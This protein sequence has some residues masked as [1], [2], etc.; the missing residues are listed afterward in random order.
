MKASFFTHKEMGDGIFRVTAAIGE[1]IYLVVGEDRAAVIDTGMGVGSLRSYIAAL[2]SKPLIVVNTH[3]HPDHAGGNIE[4]EDCRM[5][6]A[7]E[8]WYRKMCSKAYRDHDLQNFPCPALSDY[9]A[10]LAQ[11]GPLPKPLLDGEVLDL[12]GRTLTAIL[13]PG[14][15]PGS[16][17][18]LD[19]QSRSVF[20][21]DSLSAE[22]VWL[23]DEYSESL[24]T[25]FEGLTH[26]EDRAGHFSRCFVGHLPGE[27]SVQTLQ[28]TLACVKRVLLR[29]GVGTPT[30]TFAGEGLLYRYGASAILYNPNQC[31]E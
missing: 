23:Y 26:L 11:S 15:T 31:Y 3:G 14:H 6:P 19:S 5:H 17:C 8:P 12:G 18:L 16:L 30:K 21:G 7:D 9:R 2:T 27:V 10:A 1:Q 25:Y 20:A 29:D 13:V 22:A 28:N 24:R 4:F